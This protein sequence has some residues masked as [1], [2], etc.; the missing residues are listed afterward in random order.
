MDT[1]KTIE[2]MVKALEHFEAYSSEREMRDQAVQ[3]GQK[4]IEELSKQEGEPVAFLANGTR[5]KIS[6]DSRQSGGQIHGIPPELGGR[7][8]AFVAADDDCHLKLT[9]PQQRKQEQEPQMADPIP[10]DIRADLERSD[11]TVEEALRW[12]AAGKHYDTING[13]ARILDN[14]AVASNALKSLSVEYASHKGD[15]ALLDK[16]EQGEPVAYLHDDG[17]WTA[18]KTYAGR[19][20]ND[21]LLF[22]GSPKISVYTKPQ[23]LTPLTDEQC[24][25]LVATVMDAVAKEKG[26]DHAMN[27]NGDIT[28]QSA[29]RR[30]LVR[31]AHGIGVAK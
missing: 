1:I 8:V 20:L 26:L 10:D 31:A 13:Q 24:D 2:K 25:K 7:W 23:R 19:Q 16:Q 29:L 11:W 12:Y 30:A 6:Y 27:L 28:T 4:L 9:M 21:R 15:V 3:A 14:G 5:F 17:Y 22:A 18:A